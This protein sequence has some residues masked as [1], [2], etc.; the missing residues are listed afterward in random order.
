V[1]D[2]ERLSIGALFGYGLSASPVIYSYVL[3]LIMYMKYAAVE[4]GVSTAVIGTVFLVAKMWDA[5]TDP[6]VGNLSDRTRHRW[7]RRRPW[8]LAS[9]PM[10]ALFS[11]MAWAPPSGLEGSELVIWISVSVIGFYTAYTIFDVPHMA[12]GAEISLD[13][14]ERNRVFA[15]RQVLKIGGMAAAFVL[16]SHFV[17]QGIESTQTMAY[18]VGALTIILIFAG[19]RLLPPERAE[20]QGRGGQN[21]FRALADVVANPHARL[22]LFVIFIDAIG[23][24]GIGVLT[25]FVVHYVVGRPELIPALLGVNMAASLLAI[26][27]WLRLARR[28]EKRH[29]MLVSMIGSGVGYG[30]ITL[31]GPGDWPIIVVSSLIAGSSSS[32]PNILGYTL[33]SEIIDCDE[34]R[35]GE[36]KE[37]AYFAGWSF[38]NKLA[39]GIMIGIVGWALAWAGFDGQSE[40]QTEI[41]KNTMVVL[42]GGFPLV[43]YLIG[44]ATFSRF[45]LSESEHA[46]IRA[47]LDERNAESSA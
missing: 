19:V 21:P 33:K 23:T 4:L 12:L 24:G 1:Q 8:L 34:Y 2:Q 27:L 47:E 11:I 41:A 45:D 16:G 29:L 31:V 7:G 46:R 6:L 17:G 32:C 42:M 36:R 26:P 44:A 30:L 14:T 37:G 43:C 13:A 25:P 10:L 9:A 40:E 28:F 20:F 35:T 38:V 39:A 5:V 22:L 3:V 15:T 18:V